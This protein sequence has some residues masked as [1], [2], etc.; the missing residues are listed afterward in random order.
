MLGWWIL[1]KQQA[2]AGGGDAPVIASWE[3]SLGGADWLEKLV[4]EGKAT[5]LSHSGYPN[6]YTA[7]ASDVLPLIAS[8]IPPHEG[9]DVIGDDYMLPAGWMGEI[10]LKQENF[11][12]CPPSQ[13]LA[14]EV[15]D[16]S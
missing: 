11:D 12:A 7:I 4:S 1:I 8:G 13:T 2:A 15:W 14:I 5:Q 10:I 3:T 9:I 16:M 6:R